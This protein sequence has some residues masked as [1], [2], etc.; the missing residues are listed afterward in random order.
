MHACIH[1]FITMNLSHGIQLENAKLGLQ[2]LTEPN[3][4]F[5]FVFGSVW[6]DLATKKVG[7]QFGN[8]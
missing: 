7:V 8:R 6:F 4:H 1:V 2:I 5:F 3:L